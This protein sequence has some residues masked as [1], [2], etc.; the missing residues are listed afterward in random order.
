MKGY[1][2]VSYK[3]FDIRACG[4]FKKGNPN[5]AKFG[6]IKIILED[7]EKRNKNLTIR[8]TIT[9]EP[10]SERDEL[11]VYCFDLRK[12]KDSKDYLLTLWNQTPTSNGKLATIKG[13]SKVGHADVSSSS[14]E[15]GAIP[16]FQTF[17]WIKPEKNKII[18]LRFENIIG[19]DEMIKY[20]KG[21]L[22][23]YSRYRVTETNRN[24]GEVD[25]KGYRE[26]T[27]DEIQKLAPKISIKASRKKFKSED[28]SK[29]YKNISKIVYKDCLSLQFE[30][31][32]KKG[33]FPQIFRTNDLENANRNFTY[34]CDY[35]FSKEKEV[36]DMIDEWEVKDDEA[37]KDLGFYD[38]ST[39]STYFLS[40]AFVMNKD[41]AP[42]EYDSDGLIKPSKLAEFLQR[43]DI[44]ICNSLNI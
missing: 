22:H 36:K 18:S 29:H 43:N 31:E 6:S 16:G 44:K 32:K 4:Y 34:Q 7:L 28:I 11:P 30:K 1:L 12:I 23:K 20:I 9:Y 38:K 2:D 17:F 41:K 21:A 37:W 35:S 33:F 14:I 8:N 19:S 24:T 42:I 15:E 3:A 27:E 10:N 40:S 13:D 5:T 25:I 26:F 39:R